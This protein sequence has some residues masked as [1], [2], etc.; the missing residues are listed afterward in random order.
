M[1]VGEEYA[2]A[3]YTNPHDLWNLIAKHPPNRLAFEVFIGTGRLDPAKQHTIE[4]VG[5]LYGICYVLKIR[6]YPQQPQTRRPFLPQAKSILAGRGCTEHEHDA[7]AHLLLLEW[8]I[9]K[10]QIK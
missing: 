1:R 10:G 5:S 6:Q 9:A 4:L 8:R 7:L 2:T 3:L